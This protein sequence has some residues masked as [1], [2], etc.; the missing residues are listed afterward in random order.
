MERRTG[1]YRESVFTLTDGE[2]LAEACPTVM[3]PHRTGSE[4]D[5]NS[6]ADGYE[7]LAGAFAA[8]DWIL[9]WHW[10]SYVENPQRGFG[11][12]DPWDEPYEELVARVAEV[13]RRA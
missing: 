4:P 2:E 13:N 10:C 7:L 1:S 5:Q 9:G 8:E 3:S 12:K 11:L 6:R